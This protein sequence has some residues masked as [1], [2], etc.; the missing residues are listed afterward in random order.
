MANI[1]KDFESTCTSVTHT[2]NEVFENAY[3]IKSKLAGWLKW[4]NFV[5]FWRILQYIKHIGSYSQY[6]DSTASSPKVSTES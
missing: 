1:Y 2:L 6:I 3:E 4:D 5:W